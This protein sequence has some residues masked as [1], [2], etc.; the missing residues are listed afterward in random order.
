MLSVLAQPAGNAAR[1]LVSCS[2][3]AVR[4]S[5]VVNVTKRFWPACPTIA[6]IWPAGAAVATTL[7]LLV[8]AYGIFTD[9]V[10]NVPAGLL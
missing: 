10:V 4:V 6:A 3:V 2:A 1:S 8:A 5:S 7:S 9:P